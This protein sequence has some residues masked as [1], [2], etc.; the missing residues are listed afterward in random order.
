MYAKIEAIEYF[1]PRNE[2]TNEDLAKIFPE[3][4]A[5]KI[6]KKTGIF[7][8]HIASA[9]EC[10][11]DLA[12]QAAIKL[13]DSGVVKKDEIEYL[14]F[15]TQSPDYLLP[16]T[17][18]ILQERLGLAN[19][20]GALDFNLGCSG[21]IYGLSLAKGLIESGQANNV[22]LLTGETYSKYINPDDK[23][24]ISIFGDAGSATLIKKSSESQP[25]ISLPV[26]GTDGSGCSNL[27]VENVGVRNFGFYRS[28]DNVNRKNFLQMNGQEIFLFTLKTVPK[29]IDALLEKLNITKDDIN[30]FIF[31][32]ANK[33]MLDH[34]RDKSNIPEDK[35]FIYMKQIG[36]TV[37]SSIPI[38]LKEAVIQQRVKKGSAVMLVGFGVGYSWGAC[39]VTV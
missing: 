20:I 23:S 30:L 27:I 11:S 17:A 22:M 29:A 12:Y 36:N 18:C 21:Y 24:V 16:T 6:T 31:H 37:S 9:D 38:A 19:S 4:N 15:C 34:L 2:Q 7:K 39:V 1:L 26:L 32:Q 35:F 8:R 25:A 5:E 13:F 14:L 3:W 10:S 33:Y 28:N